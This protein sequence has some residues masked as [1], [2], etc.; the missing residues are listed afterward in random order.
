MLNQSMNIK[1]CV[2]III[3]YTIISY[4]DLT[5]I[6]MHFGIFIIKIVILL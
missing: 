5:H 2:I 3:L 4:L 1:Y 6:H